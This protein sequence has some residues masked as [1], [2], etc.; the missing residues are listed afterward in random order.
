MASLE[1]FVD[2]VDRLSRRL[3]RNLECCDRIL[4][5]SCE[6]TAAQAYSL[7]ALGERGEVTMNEL[8]AE[9]RLHSTTM[10]RMV[11]SLIEKGL[12]ERKQDPEDRR[13]VRVSLSE[14]G[15]ET[16]EALQDCKRRFFA[17]AFAG[18][19]DDERGAILKALR[20]LAATAEE[21]GARCCAV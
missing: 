16:V 18:L 3:M 8:A 5:A 11:D 19:S 7:L 9:M 2:E 14:R 13:V 15:Q 17:A 4:V 10:T 21:M 12:A 1:R 6:L 20:R